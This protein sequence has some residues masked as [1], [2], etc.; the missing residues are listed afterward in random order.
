MNITCIPNALSNKFEVLDLDVY[1]K[2]ISQF[3]SNVNGA[4]D[5]NLTDFLFCNF[6]SFFGCSRIIN[7]ALTNFVHTNLSNVAGN[8]FLLTHPIGEFFL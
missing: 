7:G 6:N 8:I 5:K 4:A 3:E 1:Q 2:R